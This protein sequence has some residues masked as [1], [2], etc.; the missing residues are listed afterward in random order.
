[1]AAY[2]AALDRQPL[3]ASTR[4]A[5]TVK[6]EQFAAW[7]A[8]ADL[9]VGDPLADPQARDYAARD[10]KADLKRRRLA[11]STVNQ[12][13]AAVDSFYGPVLGSVTPAAR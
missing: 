6:V 1:M 3:A 10:F 9:D 4:R 8:A 7:L 2:T 12:A 5:Y 11:P 13:L